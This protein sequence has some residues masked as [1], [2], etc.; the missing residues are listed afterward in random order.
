[1][2]AAFQY[3]GGSRGYF[4][5]LRWFERARRLNAAVG[6][7]GNGVGRRHACLSGL[8]KETNEGGQKQGGKLESKRRKRL[9]SFLSA[10]CLQFELLFRFEVF[11]LLLAYQYNIVH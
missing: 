1:M 3:I 2:C 5:S 10:E 9:R 8:Q 4:G 7:L 11:F 6:C